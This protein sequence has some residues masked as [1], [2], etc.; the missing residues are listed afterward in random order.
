MANRK[1]NML[2]GRVDDEMYKKLNKRCRELGIT[3]G[4]ALRIAL[5][6]WLR[7]KPKRPIS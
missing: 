2:T 4:F 7:K 1:Q 5:H 6:D 3:K